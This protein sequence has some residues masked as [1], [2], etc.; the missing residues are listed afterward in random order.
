MIRDP[1]T[2]KYQNDVS[3]RVRRWKAAAKVDATPAVQEQ[4]KDKMPRNS[5]EDRYPI[6]L[7]VN[8]RRTPQIEN[9]VK[10]RFSF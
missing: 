7:E 5:V 4:C 3:M 9:F 1:Q 10:K 6:H 2:N 8:P